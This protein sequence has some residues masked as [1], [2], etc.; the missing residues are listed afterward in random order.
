MKSR[1]HFLLLAIFLLASVSAS[2]YQLNA[3]GTISGSL[4]GSWSVQEGTSYIDI[5]L[6]STTY[7]GVAIEQTLE[8]TTT[9]TIAFTAVSTT[10]VSV[11]GYQTAQASSV[12]ALSVGVLNAD[13][14]VYDLFGRSVSS[15][16]R[17]GIYIQNGRKLLAR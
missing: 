9:K 10:G 11:W 12:Q 3:D 16:D 2:V 6:G 4:S 7:Q 1:N 13:M 5:K 14:P 15:I 17:K 8:P